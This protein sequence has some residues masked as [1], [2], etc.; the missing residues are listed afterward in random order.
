MFFPA[1][2]KSS[3]HSQKR[4]NIL[5]YGESGQSALLGLECTRHRV[6]YAPPGSTVFLRLAAALGTPCSFQEDASIRIGGFGA[7]NRT[8]GL[9]ADHTLDT[10]LQEQLPWFEENSGIAVV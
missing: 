10:L 1:R 8:L 9:F 5:F 6:A 4:P 3:G 2:Q 7:E